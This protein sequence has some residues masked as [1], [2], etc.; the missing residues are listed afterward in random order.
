MKL[1]LSSLFTAFLLSLPFAPASAA[2]SV[3]VTIDLGGATLVLT[4][5]PCQ[6]PEVTDFI[7]RLGDWQQ[8]EPRGGTIQSNDEDEVYKICYVDFSDGQGGVF[9]I[10]ELGGMGHIPKDRLDG[11][12][13]AMRKTGGSAAAS[14]ASRVDAQ[15]ADERRRA[16]QSARK[17][18]ADKSAAK[19]AGK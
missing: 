1:I 16:G 11:G 13:S 17:N 2:I 6:L 8:D 9:V 19:S 18:A 14:H 10:D 5:K 7:K 12:K 15:T 3:N 4:D